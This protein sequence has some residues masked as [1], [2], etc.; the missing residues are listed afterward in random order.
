VS[1]LGFEPLCSRLSSYL[2]LR[3]YLVGW[4]PSAADYAVWGQLQG[5][6]E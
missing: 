4:E 6:V 5:E 3:S 2:A 1:G